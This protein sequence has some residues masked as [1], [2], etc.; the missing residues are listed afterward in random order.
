MN[1]LQEEGSGHFIGGL[2]MLLRGEGGGRGGAGLS[3]Q[4]PGGGEHKHRLGGAT[5]PA[6]RC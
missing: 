1:G 2:F 5:A 3:P 6:A 4:P